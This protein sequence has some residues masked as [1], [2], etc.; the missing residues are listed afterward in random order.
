MY[1]LIN[2]IFLR[3]LQLK[4][5]KSPKCSVGNPRVKGSGFRVQGLGFR[6]QGSG[7]RDSG[8]GF[9][10]SGSQVGTR[11]KDKKTETAAVFRVQGS[12]AGHGGMGHHNT[13]Q[14][15]CMTLGSLSCGKYGFIVY[16]SNTSFLVSTVVF[17]GFSSIV[18]SLLVTSMSRFGLVSYP[19]PLRFRVEGLGFEPPPLNRDY[20]RD[21]NI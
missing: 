7:I 11:G 8:L 4:T 19:R 12:R 14:E 3:N 18:H 6:V 17:H 9:R 1:P 10:R 16:Y 13:C 15:S 2:P 5:S 21:P 20:Y